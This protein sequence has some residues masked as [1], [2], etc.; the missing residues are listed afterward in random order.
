MPK[1]HKSRREVLDAIQSL[2]PLKSL[3]STHEGHFDYELDLEVT[4][5]GRNYRGKNV[6]PYVRLLTYD[7]NEAVIV[8]GDWGGNTFFM[9]VDGIAEVYVNAPNRQQV[10][11]AEFQPGTLFGEMSVLAGLPR[12]AT[13]KAPANQKAKLL[14]IQRPAL[15]LLR[16][17]PEF[18]EELD[19]NYRKHGRNAILEDIRLLTN[20][21]A[22]FV[23]ELSSI[24]T[25]RVFAKNHTLFR[26]GDPVNRIYVVKQGWLKRRQGATVELETQIV[27][28]LGRGFIFGLEGL[29]KNERWPYTVT[30]M[31]RAEVLEISINKLRQALELRDEFIR[32]ATAFTPPALGSRINFGKVIKKADTR[33]LVRESQEDLIATGLVDGNNLLVM[34]MDLCVRCGNCSLACHKIHGQSRLTRR[35]VHVTRLEAARLG[36][37]QSVLSPEV[38]MHCA[39]PECMTGCPTGAI[40]RFGQGQVD[41]EPKTCIGCGDCATQC[42]YNAISMISRKVEASDVTKNFAW[43][44]KDLL[45]LQPDPLPAAVEATDDLLAVKCNLC[46]GT[47]INPPDSQEAKYSCEENCPTGALARITPIQYFAEI[48]QI[49]GLLKIDETHALG[50]NIHKSDPP[51]KM[52]HIA[53]ILTTVVLLAATLLGFQRYGMGAS[54]FGILNMRWITGVV[55]LL[56]IAL[57]MTY[58][59]RRQTYTK[60]KGPLRYWLLVHTYAG[61]IAG[62]MLLLHGGADSGGWLTT[63]LMWSFDV[64]IVTGLFGIAIYFVAPRVLTKIEGSPLLI[65]DLRARRRELQKEMATIV[66]QPSEPLREMVLKRVIPRFVTSAYLIRQ[67]LQR[68]KIDDMI[69]EAKAE[70]K[71][72][73]DYLL[74]ARLTHDLRSAGFEAQLPLAK[75]II[76]NPANETFL[77]GLPEFAKVER[78]LQFLAAIEAAKEE[79]RNLERAVE[80]AATLRRVDALIYMHLLLKMWLPPHVLSTSLMLALMTVHIIQVVYYLAR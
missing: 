38:C 24:S 47:S 60:R 63:A 77:I 70:Y 4:V 11:V 14:E 3:L 64:V 72:A 59:F 73:G 23:K 8:E 56:G 6:G 49:E 42:P 43:K 78:R 7:P 21:D 37:V 40:G 26:E 36:A 1:E 66:S 65:D 9:L 48:G 18:S 29:M 25:F 32:A 71:S 53:G 57:V 5:Y 61:V 34:D 16:K 28:Y 31:S 39:D 80:A 79:R 46:N 67:Y 69:A 45:R 22:D 44:I 55:G 68:E 13:I 27:D 15:R 50:R 51:K 58:P 52:L 75:N 12:N 62:L 54:I 2:P 20:L 19:K 76:A 30:L 10:K 33:K 17:I 41:I 74:E 35:G